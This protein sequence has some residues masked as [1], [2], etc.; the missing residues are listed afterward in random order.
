MLK[1]RIAKLEA[2]RG[3]APDP[4]ADAAFQAIVAWLEAMGAR[5]AAGDESARAEMIATMEALKAG[6]R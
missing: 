1:G 2:A 4:D 6:E 3:Q 5:I